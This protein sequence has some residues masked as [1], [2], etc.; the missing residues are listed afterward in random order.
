MKKNVQLLQNLGHDLITVQI[1]KVQPNGTF[2]YILSRRVTTPTLCDP[3]WETHIAE[4]LAQHST[5]GEGHYLVRAFTDGA[6][7]CTWDLFLKG[8]PAS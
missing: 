1:D 3:Q 2:R 7:Q 6:E 5:G 4:E 8:A